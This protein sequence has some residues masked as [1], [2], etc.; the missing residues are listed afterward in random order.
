MRQ[1]RADRRRITDD[2]DHRTLEA[3]VGH[4]A[5]EPGQRVDHARRPGRRGRARAT[6]S[7]AGSP[8]SRGGGRGRTGRW[9][10][11]RGRR[12]GRPTTCRSSCRS[13]AWAS[14]RPATSR[15][16]SYSAR[17][18]SGGMKPRA[19]SAAGEHGRDPSRQLD[20]DRGRLELL[21]GRVVVVWCSTWKSLVEEEE[22][23]DPQDAE[24]EHVGDVRE[25]GADER[26]PVALVG[27]VRRPAHDDGRE[28]EADGHEDPERQD[29]LLEVALARLAPHPRPAQVE[30]RDGADA[31]RQDVRE[32]GEVDLL[33]LRQ[34]RAVHVEHEDVE[35]EQQALPDDHVDHGDGAVLEALALDRV[36]GARDEGARARGRRRRCHDPTMVQAGTTRR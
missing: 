9:R 36:D 3:G 34:L 5:A 2:G 20:G 8:P 15:P 23:Q 4:R 31:D 25:Q 6:P 10:A 28:H 12:R 22:P 7:R 21:V 18:S 35:E 16:A 14:R 32:R 19:A 13:R 33:G 11:R 24:G 27:E 26:A 30:G 17:P 1:C 29:L